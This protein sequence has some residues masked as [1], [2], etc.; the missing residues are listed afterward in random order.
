[1]RRSLAIGANWTRSTTRPPR[2]AVD[3]W[4]SP[5]VA[6]DR[7]ARQRKSDLALTWPPEYT[8]KLGTDQGGR[9]A[10]TG[11]SSS[12]QRFPDALVKHSFAPIRRSEISSGRSLRSKLRQSPARGYRLLR[13]YRRPSW[14]IRSIGHHREADL[15][16][17]DSPVNPTLMPLQIE[18]LA[19]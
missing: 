15:V 17:R 8:V 16:A 2:S 14:P 6:T 18:C 19:R 10:V 12:L 1:M 3:F 5:H 7:L 4:L 13:T 9:C 11:L